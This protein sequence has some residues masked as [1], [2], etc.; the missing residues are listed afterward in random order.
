MT[1]YMFT[2]EVINYKGRLLKRIKRLSDGKLGGYIEN[3][4]NL[5]Q[6]GECFV[7]DN[8]KVYGK[9]RVED[10]AQIHDNAIVFEKAHVY[11]NANIYNNVL[12]GGSASINGDVKAYDNVNIYDESRITG[13]VELH[14][15]VLVG[16]NAKIYDSAKIYGNSMILGD[17]KVRGNAVINGKSYI[18]GNAEITQSAMISDS[19]IGNNVKVCGDAKISNEKLDGN[20]IINTNYSKLMYFTFGEDLFVTLLLTDKGWI[21]NS[22]CGNSLTKE[23]FLKNIDCKDFLEFIDLIS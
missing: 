19:D 18:R 3:K 22:E 9:A 23:E 4:T 16:F 10:N 21:F 8:A 6:G 12:I 5:D 1:A 14:N 13:N 20:I 2:G 17:V 15:D 7:H 11:G